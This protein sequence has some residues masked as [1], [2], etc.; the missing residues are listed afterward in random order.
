MSFKVVR[1]KVDGLPE[2]FFGSPNVPFRCVDKAEM[3]VSCG[4]IWI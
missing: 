1:G 2:M 4:G 3:K